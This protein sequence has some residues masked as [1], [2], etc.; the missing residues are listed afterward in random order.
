ML[1]VVPPSHIRSWVWSPVLSVAGFVP[2]TVNRL[3]PG[4]TR[5]GEGLECV[6]GQYIGSRQ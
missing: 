1:E 5:E 6:L 3:L 4:V 2:L